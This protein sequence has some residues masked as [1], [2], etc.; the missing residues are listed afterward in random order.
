MSAILITGAT[1]KQ[2]GAVINE[3]LRRNLPHDL[4]AVTRNT[5]SATAQRLASQSPK[6]HLVQGD[7]NEPVQLFQHARAA[8]SNPIWG[9][10]SVQVAIGSKNEEQ[11]GKALIDEAL[12]QDVKQFVYSSVDRGGEKS[13]SNPTNIPHFITKHNVE[14]HLLSRT[15]SPQ[16]TMNW[17][18]LRP[19][20]FMENLTPDFMG[21]VFATSWRA[22]LKQKPLQIVATSDIGFF[23]AE[24]FASA[25]AFQGKAISL[26]GDELTFQQMAEIFKSKMGRNVPTTFELPCRLLMAMVA[27]LGTMFRW[28]A[29]EG[30]GADIEALRKM[31]PQ[32]KDFGS[33]LE[34]ES[35]FKQ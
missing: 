30:Y 28:F 25:D 27:E 1:G 4:L 7:L 8:T 18:I 29:D 14:Q 31:N 34:T 24:A 20:A 2:G 15:N 11:Q 35:Q 6:I 9:V 10:F 32:L 12:A 23:A 17:T 22:M 16:N 19:V 26:A 21:K 5:Q 33:W 3:L 13:I